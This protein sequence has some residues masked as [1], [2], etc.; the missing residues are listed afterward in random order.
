MFS[1]DSP[2]PLCCVLPEALGQQDLLTWLEE[3]QEN[4]FLQASVGG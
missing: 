1:Q 3:G 4:T 2:I